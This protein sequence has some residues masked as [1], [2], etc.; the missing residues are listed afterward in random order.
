[1]P[2]PPTCFHSPFGSFNLYR[3]PVRVQEDLQAWCSADRLLLQYAA[4]HQLTVPNLVVNDTH[5][6]LCIALQPL[7]L[8]TDSAL[9]IRALRNNEA[10]NSRPATPVFLS[11]ETPPMVPDLVVMRIPKQRAYFDYQLS[12]LSQWLP[13]GSTLLAAGM[14]KHLSPHAAGTLEHY[15]GTTQRL[16]GQ[17]K[18]RLFRATKDRQSDS[19]KTDKANNTNDTNHLTSSYLLNDLHAPLVSLPNV[20]SREKL[21]MGSRFLIEH[22]HLLQPVATALDLAC[23]NG[24]LG[25]VAMTRGLTQNLAFCDES[26]LAIAS[27]RLNAHRLFPDAA[28]HF[29]FHHGD[30]IEDY[31]GQKA[32]LILCNPP[33]HHEHTVDELVGVRL[34]EQA[35]RHLDPGGTLFLVANRHLDYRGALGSHFATVQQ[36]A[37]N[38]KFR[39]FKASKT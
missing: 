34:V 14:D 36:C 28:H 6:A 38:K 3:Y 5:G 39:L 2:S 27:A 10:A 35:A 7:A 16:P 18:A 30:G 25:L 23:G 13:P 19:N 33:F 11:T 21:D 9:A 31:Q 26:A 29:Y 15:I 20:F 4:E 12:Q 24:V 8:W 37:A 17:H 22:M 1:V 32:E